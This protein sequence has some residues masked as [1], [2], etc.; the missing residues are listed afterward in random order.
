MSTEYANMSFDNVYA[1]KR[2]SVSMFLCADS[3]DEAPGLEMDNPELIDALAK[4]MAE[5]EWQIPGEGSVSVDRAR[6]L[7]L[8]WRDDS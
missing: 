1:A 8:D 4:E 6:E 5:M 7:I 2:A 3:P